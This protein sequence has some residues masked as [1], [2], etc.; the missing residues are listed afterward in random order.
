MAKTPVVTA[1]VS[2]YNSE[3]L[4]EGCLRDLERQTLASDLEIIVI[5]SG[6]LQN[7]GT[8]VREL[9]G[10]Y[11]NI[12][13]ERTE[14]ET[15]YGAW[16]RA[17][18]MAS[19]RYVINANTDDRHRPESFELLAT[20]LDDDRS[21]DL[22]YGDWLTTGRPNETFL[23]N[24]GNPL[25]TIRYPEYFEPLCMLH[26]MLSPAPMWRKGVLDDVG[27]FDETLR[28]AGD[29]EWN[30]RFALQRKAGHLPVVLGLFR[31]SQE[32]T[33]QGEAAQTEP[34]EVF[35]R[36]R[37]KENVFRLY[38]KAGWPVG[39][40]RGRRLALDDMGRRARL[41]IPPWQWFGPCQD[42]GLAQLCET[43]VHEG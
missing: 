4:I 13:Y 3:D 2:T 38:E 39:D 16:N 6:S 41:Y 15:L 34:A 27:P 18:R 5:D 33:S 1:M 37:T 22:V 10:E 23:Q 26:F 43:W 24:S 30:I 31:W 19:G 35:G 12:V 11:G 40:S 7:E 17:A 9:Q 32:S 42:I 21:I 29:L 14:R 25:M 8:I 20:A 36:Y 28:S